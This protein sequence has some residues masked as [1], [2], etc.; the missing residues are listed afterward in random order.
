MMPGTP[1]NSMGMEAFHD[2]P[3][4]QRHRLPDDHAGAQGLPPA[5]PERGQRPLLQP[6][7]LSGRRRQRHPVRCATTTPVAESHRRGLHRSGPEPRRGGGCAG[8]PHRTSSR[9]RWHGTEGPDWIQIGTEGGFL[10]A[11][12]VIPPQHITWVIDPTLFNAGLVDQHSLLLGPAERADI[13]VDFS[14]VRRPDADP[15]QRRPG[16]LPG[17]RPALRLLHR[18]RRTCGTRAARLRRCPATARTPAPS[19]RSR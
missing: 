18:Q 12:V 14:G 2:T 17:A 19:C 6:Q 4:R 1:F 8:D 11:P 15:V 9:P 13:I 16:G 3:D 10:P 5:H 7:P